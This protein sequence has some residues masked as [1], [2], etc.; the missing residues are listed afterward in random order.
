MMCWLCESVQLI[1]SLR[2]DLDR[3]DDA[4][5]P[6][7]CFLLSDTTAVSMCTAQMEELV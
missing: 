7:F 3:T 6:A 2:S 5:G 1:N 4:A